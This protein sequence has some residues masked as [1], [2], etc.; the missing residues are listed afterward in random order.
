MTP[1]TEVFVALR[2]EGTEVWRPVNA[3]Q[4]AHNLYQIL[5]PVPDDEEWEFQPSQVVL[6]EFKKFQD[7]SSGLV[8]VKAKGNEQ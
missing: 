6:C 5:G 1:K 3:R 7:G 2:G 4:V 8:A